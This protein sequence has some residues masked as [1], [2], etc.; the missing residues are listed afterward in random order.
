MIRTS[1]LRQVGYYD[2]GY[3]VAS[4]YEMFFRLTRRFQTANLQQVLIRKEAHPN[5]LSIGHRR[6]SLM[7][8]LR[9]Q[10]KHFDRLSVGSYLGVLS[11][12]ALLLLPYGSVVA[13]KSMVGYSR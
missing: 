12:L 2:E 3:P 9:A 1:A 11:T 4:D 6:R 8:R 5:S 13:V 7:F 10:C